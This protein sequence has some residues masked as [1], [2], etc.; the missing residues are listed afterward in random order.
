MRSGI[1]DESLGWSRCDT[2]Q[3]THSVPAKK[4]LYVMR[5]CELCGQRPC[6]DQDV[7]FGVKLL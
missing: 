5:K 4:W 3:A 2:S 6:R 7:V 1:K